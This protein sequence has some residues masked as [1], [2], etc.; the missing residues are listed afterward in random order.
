MSGGDIHQSAQRTCYQCKSSKKKC[1][2]L[3]P[4]CSRCARLSMDCL[5]GEPS[6]LGEQQSLQEA[7]DSR[8]DKVFERLKS[9]EYA[10]KDL[11][12]VAA[13]PTFPANKEE[14]PTRSDRKD[15]RSQADCELDVDLLRPEPMVSVLSRSVLRVLEESG[16][17]AAA[18][19]DGYLTTYHEWIPMVSQSKLIR[20]LQEGIG[21]STA[22]HGVLILAMHLL[23]T[24]I[25]EHPESASLSLSPWYLACKGHFAQEANLNEPYV[26]LVQAGIL[27]VLFEHLQCI[28]SRAYTTFGLATRLAYALELG[29]QADE[30]SNLDSGDFTPEKEEILITWWVL[31][32]LDKY[33]ISSFTGCSVYRT[34]RPSTYSC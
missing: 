24:P 33:A 17:T 20:V 23:I 26:E 10:I 31:R 7:A 28:Q 9:L 29:V 19:C 4:V 13:G 16:T 14:A 22:T 12:G 15:L 32:F 21:V 8:F 1:D 6:T 30:S 27:I 18:I 34:R 11:K 25:A 3:L 2:K 5:Y